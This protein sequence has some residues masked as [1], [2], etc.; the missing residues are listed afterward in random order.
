MCLYC[1]LESCL[2]RHTHF[3]TL[4]VIELP[5]TGAMPLGTTWCSVSCAGIF[6]ISFTT[7]LQIIDPFNPKH[8]ASHRAIVCSISEIH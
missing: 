7:E 4:M 6:Q 1:A 5:Y 2:H 8:G 3:Y